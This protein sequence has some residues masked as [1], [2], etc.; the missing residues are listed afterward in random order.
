MDGIDGK[1]V[2]VTGGSSGLGEAT[3][4][5]L[6]ERGAKVMLGARR[7]ENLERIVSEIKEDGGTAFLQ[8]H[9]R[10]RIRIRWRTWSPGRSMSLAG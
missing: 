5:L 2:V 3:A 7:E 10:G 8:G 4:K 6:A 1:V 9:G